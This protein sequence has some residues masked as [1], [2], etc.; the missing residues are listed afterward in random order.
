MS[1]ADRLLRLA[2]ATIAVSPWLLAGCAALSVDRPE[3]PIVQLANRPSLLRLAIAQLQYGNGARFQ[4]CGGGACPKRT[5]K[6][7][8]SAAQRSNAD[9]VVVPINPP[10][11]ATLPLV[12]TA[13]LVQAELSKPAIEPG[14]KT[15]TIT[16]AS[17]AATLTAATRKTLDAVAPEVRTA[18]AVEI[19]GRTDDLGGAHLNEVLARNRALAVRDYLHQ[20]ALPDDTLLRVSSRGACCYVAGNDTEEGRAAN[21]RVEIEFKRASATYA[22][23]QPQ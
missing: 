15:V 22:W 14:A 11:H 13:T 5:G 17:G 3:E 19:R 7:L 21:R 20:Q 16:F 1:C 2:V 18:E 8:T 6:T 9:A 4:I 12:S 23:E 10:T